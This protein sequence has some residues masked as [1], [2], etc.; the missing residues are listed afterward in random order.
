MTRMTEIQVGNGKRGVALALTFSPDGGQLAVGRADGL[1]NPSIIDVFQVATGQK[2]MELSSHMGPI[3]DLVFAPDHQSLVG[4]GY[5]R[6]IRF[7]DLVTGQSRAVLRGHDDTVCSIRFAPDGWT[8]ISGGV[9][10]TIR[11]WR[12]TA[13]TPLVSSNAAAGTSPAASRADW[14]NAQSWLIVAAPG[15][16]LE[17]YRLGL[18]YAQEAAREEPAN[19]TILNTLGVSQYRVGAHAD[20]LATLRRADAI[21]QGHCCDVA[22]IAMT[23]NRLGRTVEARSELAR[24]HALMRLPRRSNEEIAA[25]REALAELDAGNESVLSIPNP[26]PSQPASH[27][28]GAGTRPANLARTKNC[29]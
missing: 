6:T 23:L 2:Q 5:D 29:D 28:I 1:S 19:G 27:I 25:Y 3:L 15:R 24:L 18:K 14:L 12:A 20:A 26:L 17:Q 7:W 8:L 16:S 13:D 4:A 22:F 10:R 9:D 21:N 11:Y